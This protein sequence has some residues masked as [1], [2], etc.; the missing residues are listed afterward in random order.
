M[1]LSYASPEEQIEYLK[2]ILNS[3]AEGIYAV[4]T[5]GRITLCNNSFLQLLGYSA[6]EEVIGRTIHSEIHH[7]HPEVAINGTCNC[8][9]HLAA[10]TG[11]GSFV[12]FEFFYRKD[13]TKFPVEYRTRPITQHGVLKGALCTFSDITEQVNAKAEA[14]ESTDRINLAMESGL[15]SGTYRWDIQ[16]NLVQ[17]D[18]RFATLFSITSDKAKEGLT[19]E[20]VIPVIHPDDQAQVQKEIQKTIEQGGLY[21]SQY[22]LKYG[23]GWRWV[24][25]SGKVIRDEKNEPQLFFGVISDIN[26]RKNEEVRYRDA[27][28]QLRLAQE[29]AGIGLFTVDIAANTITGSPEFYRLFGFE[30]STPTSPEAFEALCLPEDKNLISTRE[31]RATGAAALNSEYRIRRHSDGAIRWMSRRSEIICDPAGTPLTMVGAVLD[32]TNEKNQELSL[33]QSREQYRYL[34]NSIDDGFCVIDV[35]FDENDHPVDYQYIE[36]NPAFARHTGLENTQGKR[37]R[38]ILPNH[39]KHWF[40]KYGQVALTGEPTRFVAVANTVGERDFEVYA[41]RVERPEQRRIAVLFQDISDRV[42]ATKALSDAKLEA[43]TANMA[44]TEFLANMSHEIRTPMNAIV[45]LSNI[46]GMSSPLTE[47]QRQYIS[48]LRMSADS[49]LNLINDLLDIS[50]IEARTIE[51]EEIPFSLAQLIEEVTS[52]MAVRVKEKGL[53]FTTDAGAIRGKQFLGDPTRLRQIILNLCSNAVKFTEQGSIHIAITCHA[54]AEPE[55][56]TISITVK[57]TGIGVA[58][59]KIE[60]IFKKFMQADSTINRKYGGTGLGLAITK[61]LSETM[62]GTIRLETELGKGSEFTVSLPLRVISEKPADENTHQDRVADDR[63]E[64]TTRPKLLLVEDYE[65]NVLVATILL[66]NYGYIVE[67][68]ANGIEAV[69]KAKS[70]DYAAILMDVQMYGMN[71]LDATSLIREHEQKAGLPRVPIIGM[72][73]HALAGDRERCLAAGMDDY[74]SKPFVAEELNLKIKKFISP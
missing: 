51:L 65:P 49:L 4:N 62:G 17:G 46:L 37:V 18:E 28:N 74:V 6:K 68:A 66:E 43:E 23:E 42:R 39:E 32:I 31:S 53:V 7:T 67:E 33:K 57:D 63:Y 30:T 3:A 50:K 54:H 52:I 58:K 1:P 69:E 48:T 35:I 73:A 9:I 55:K 70:R 19:L 40:E 12:P 44:K 71:G 16:K 45:G 64:G 59:D 2:L 29:A 47:K 24:Q 41:F 36:V 8:P 61:T 15:L 34:F 60:T 21:N 25:A 20:E 11:K 13:G 5:E 26:L 38:D 14:R 72:T 27:Q 22:R 10:S 56:E